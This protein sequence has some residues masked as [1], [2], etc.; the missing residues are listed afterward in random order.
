MAV[1]MVQL[2]ITQAASHMEPLATSCVEGAP[3]IRRHAVRPSVHMAYLT[4]PCCNF[5]A[6]SYIVRQLAGPP[7]RTSAFGPAL[8]VHS[9]AA[10]GVGGGV[11]AQHPLL[12][13]VPGGV[14]GRAWPCIALQ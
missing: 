12:C 4:L 6:L 2:H 3:S 11:A 1:C 9:A 5:A 7:H 8:H 14:H 10:S 13:P